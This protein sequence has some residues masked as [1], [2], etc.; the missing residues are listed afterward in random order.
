MLS[1]VR[2]ADAERR[3]RRE[4]YKLRGATKGYANA[5]PNCFA[6]AA[7]TYR[8]RRLVGGAVP[9]APL[10]GGQGTGRPTSSLCLRASVPLC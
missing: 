6:R 3:M 2:R 7:H 9:C 10:N 8:L 4:V 1:G 5:S